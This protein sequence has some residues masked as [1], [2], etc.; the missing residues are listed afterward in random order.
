MARKLEKRGKQSFEVRIP[1]ERQ[2][3]IDLE[4]SKLESKDEGVSVSLKYF[5]AE[6]ECFSDWNAGDLK[7][8]SATLAKIKQ[9]NSGTLQGYRPLCERHKNAPAEGRFARPAELSED[10]A[11]FEIKVDPSNAARI[12]GA[13]VGS[14]FYLVWLD[15]LHA[16]YPE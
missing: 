13:F 11:F 16:V 10:I 2:T 15:R 5:R 7:K 3:R 6:T 4:K 12:H 9:V 8:F 14:V 1:A